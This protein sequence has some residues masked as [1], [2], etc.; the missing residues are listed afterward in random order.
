MFQK[1][2]NKSI[3]RQIFKLLIL[4]FDMV[5]KGSIPWNKGKHGIYSEEA[6]R[7]MSL[8][9]K[10]KPSS[11]K[12]KHLSEEH[13]KKLSEAHKGKPTWNKGLK[14][15]T[16]SGMKGKHQSEGAR[17]K[18][19][20]S[21]KGKTP[22]NKGK[23]HTEESK[24]KMSLSHKGK[25]TW[26]KG[27]HGI[28]TLEQLKRM[29]E[30]HKGQ[31]HWSGR[32]HSEESKRKM[33]EVHKG[34]KPSEE[35]RRLLSESYKRIWFSPE[36]RQKRAEAQKRAMASPE[37]RQKMSRTSK[38]NWTNPDYR[39]KIIDI[40]TTPENRER[41]RKR[42]LELFEA[43]NFPGVQNTKPERQIKE[44][45]IKRRYKEGIDFIHQYKFMNKF[46][47]D[48]CFPQ[49]KVIVEVYGDYWHANPKKYLSGS[50][51]HPQQIKG[52]GRDKSK[53]AYISKADNNSW[54]YL[55]LWEMDIKEDVA[56]CVDKIE[57]VLSKKR[58]IYKVWI[59]P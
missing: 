39:K 20:L 14:G 43:G 15:I 57:E 46:M 7:K 2:I 49:Q 37:H 51:L 1:F 22:G 59:I 13:R 6:K 19:S 41:N 34:K 45:L 31:D 48:F 5:R 32:K 27:K 4:G 16:I 11:K 17:R 55:V 53:E 35:T 12:G 29:S 58:Q 33:S 21:H 44:E 23:S 18:M 40:M 26:N 30:S 38:K 36:T 28:Y 54:T 50:P 56:K 52:I 25:L 42:I 8:A 10:G 3:Y 47:C 9:N 24:R